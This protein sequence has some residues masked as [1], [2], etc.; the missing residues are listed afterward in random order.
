MYSLSKEFH[1]KVVQHF[2]R[3]HR[4]HQHNNLVCPNFKKRFTWIHEIISSVWSLR[5]SIWIFFWHLN[6]RGIA[7]RDRRHNDG[8]FRKRIKRLLVAEKTVQRMPNIL[9]SDTKV[10]SIFFSSHNEPTS[11]NVLFDSVIQ[12]KIFM[13]W[14]LNSGISFT[15]LSIY[16]TMSLFFFFFQGDWW[17]QLQYTY[18]F[19]TQEPPDE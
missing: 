14:N 9:F 11:M 7:I 12:R 3:H 2:S 6:L 1:S 8:G 19:S 16:Q 5:K 4:S 17:Q 15:S 13:K 18:S 10:N